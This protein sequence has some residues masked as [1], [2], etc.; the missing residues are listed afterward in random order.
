MAHIRHGLHVGI[1]RIDDQFYLNLKAI[2]TL[3]HADY[4]K[5]NPLID[6][7]LEGVKSPKINAFVDGSELKG[8]ELRAA[9][10]DFKFG[11]KHGG[12]FNRVAIFG[13][14][15][16]QE[17]TAKMASWFISGEVKFFHNKDDALTWLI[18]E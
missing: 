11:L 2:G 12:Q 14:E 4:E 13:H 10:D 17:Y 7:A 16:W 5:I 18:E 9:W 15:K 8:W 1:E 6:A 3:T